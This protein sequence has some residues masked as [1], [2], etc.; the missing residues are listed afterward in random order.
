MRLLGGGS[1]PKMIGVSATQLNRGL[2]MEGHRRGRVRSS[3]YLQD[4][5][6]GPRE[7]TPNDTLISDLQPQNLRKSIPK[8]SHPALVFC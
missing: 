1:Q 7:P 4:R 2:T 8:M 6:R 3:V 5:E